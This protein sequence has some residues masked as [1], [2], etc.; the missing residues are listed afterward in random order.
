M[1][2]HLTA[3]EQVRDLSGCV[4]IFG[5]SAFGDYPEKPSE[6]IARRLDGANI[7]GCDVRGVVL[8]EDYLEMEE[9]VMHSLI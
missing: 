2:K 7:Q 5:F 6:I 9:V 8:P 4:F 3:R 1:H